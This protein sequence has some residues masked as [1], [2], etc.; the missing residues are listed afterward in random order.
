MTRGVRDRETIARLEIA[1][2]QIAVRE[3][4]LAIARE[5]W[6]R[7][8]LGVV[9]QRERDKCCSPGREWRGQA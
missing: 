2:A 8:K 6:W 4:R 7:E 9:Q 3:R 1:R 5:R